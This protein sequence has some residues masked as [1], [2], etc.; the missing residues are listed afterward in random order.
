MNNWVDILK[1][2]DKN[3]K[4]WAKCVIFSAIILAVAV[5]INTWNTRDNSK[6]FNALKYICDIII[7]LTTTVLA[8]FLL[9]IIYNLSESHKLNAISTVSYEGLLPDLLKSLEKFKGRYRKNESV[10]VELH[11]YDDIG[12][13]DFYKVVFEYQYA[14]I[15]KDLKELQF[16]FYRIFDGNINDFSGGLNEQY[17]ICDFIWGVDESGFKPKIISDDDYTISQLIVGNNQ[18]SDLTKYRNLTTFNLKKKKNSIISYNIPFDNLQN[19]NKNELVQLSYRVTL[20]LEKEDILL[21]TH[22]LPTEKAKIVF[23][24]A[25]VR[26]EISVYGIPVTGTI[27]PLEPEEDDDSKIKYVISGW[28]LPKQGYVFGWWKKKN[29]KKI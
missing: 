3:K 14:T 6:A 17:M 25:E 21:I 27:E 19:V 8:T 22:E 13:E 23:D 11:K 12:K 26:E 20:P 2:V 1:P 16:K 5:G 15:F 24:Y 29:G 4:F 10:L 18:I 28:I 9:N 7:A